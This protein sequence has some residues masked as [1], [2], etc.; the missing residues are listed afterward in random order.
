MNA[1]QRPITDT[2][3]LHGN[4]ELKVFEYGVK[5]NGETILQ[6]QSYVLKLCNVHVII[7]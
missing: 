4:F 3:W 2:A 6:L 1:E 7:N 5:Y